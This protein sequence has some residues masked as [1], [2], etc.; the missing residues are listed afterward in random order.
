MKT[1]LCDIIQ[2]RS[3]VTQKDKTK[4]CDQEENE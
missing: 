4:P 3:P 2:S 1:I